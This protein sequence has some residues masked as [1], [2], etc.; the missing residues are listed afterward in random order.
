M[1]EFYIGTIQRLANILKLTSTDNVWKAVRKVK[2]EST[3]KSLETKE[4]CLE[5]YGWYMDS[6]QLARVME[7]EE[8]LKINYYKTMK[9]K[10]MT[11]NDLEIAAEMFIY[12][13][14]CPGKIFETSG[15]CIFH[16]Q[17]I[18]I[19]RSCRISSVYIVGGWVGCC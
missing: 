8:Q 1:I 14:T 15:Q 19:F 7:V 3:I 10:N 16:L 18:I 12:L 9:F 6:D 11:R 2:M 17:I 13:K 5:G 4:Q